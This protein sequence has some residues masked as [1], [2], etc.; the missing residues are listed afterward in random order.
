[1]KYHILVDIIGGESFI[2][3]R[4]CWDPK[5]HLFWIGEY[6]SFKAHSTNNVDAYACMST[7][8]LITSRNTYTHILPLLAPPK[9]YGGRL[10]DWQSHHIHRYWRTHHLLKTSIIPIIKIEKHRYRIQFYFSYTIIKSK[11][12]IGKTRQDG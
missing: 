9:Q 3:K 4:L 7:V 8:T 6:F 10:P 11:L 5:W 1:M 2:S 12:L